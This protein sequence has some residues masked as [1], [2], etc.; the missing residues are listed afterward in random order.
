MKRV[1]LL[2]ALLG[3]IFT[4]CT[5][6][7]VDNPTNPVS[8]TDYMQLQIGNFWVYENYRFDSLGNE[9]VIG[10]PDSLVITGDTLI[11]GKLYYKKLSVI[12]G[13]TSYLRDSSGFLVDDLGKIIFSEKDFDNILRVDTIGPNLAYVEYK[14]V[15]GD[16][17]INIPMGSYPSLD[18]RGTVT[19]LQPDYPHGTQ[20]TY[21]FWAD[22]LGMIKSSAYYYSNPALR[23][24]QRLKAFGHVEQ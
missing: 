12:Q 4:S 14:M 6:D 15:E 23:I 17:I 19:S 18:Y 24:G 7:D 1:I 5:K 8:S 9:I 2:I 22:G 13:Y 3:F 10:D 21:I 11:R 20:Y 16:T